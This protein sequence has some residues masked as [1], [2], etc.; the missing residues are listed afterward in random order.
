M[1]TIYPFTPRPPPPPPKKKHPKISAGIETERLIWSSQNVKC[2]GETDFLK[3]DQNSQ[4]EFP[5]GKCA[6]HLLFATTEFQAFRLKFV[7]GEMPVEMEHVPGIAWKFPFGVLMRPL[8]H[9]HKWPPCNFETFYISA[10]KER[11]E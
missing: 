2:P 7:P 4:T 9:I 6:F 5:N 10:T 8:P 1:F 3:A 11:I